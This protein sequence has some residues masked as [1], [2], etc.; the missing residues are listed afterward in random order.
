MDMNDHM[1]KMNFTCLY[2]EG[3]EKNPSNKK[4]LPN[5]I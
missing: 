1:L 5:Q 2:E 4:D 3:K